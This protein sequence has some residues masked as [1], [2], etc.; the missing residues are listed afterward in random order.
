MKNMVR[1]EIIYSPQELG[2]KKEHS[3]EINSQPFT[4]DDLTKVVFVK[5]V[6]KDQSTDK[7]IQTIEKQYNFD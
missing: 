7:I 2:E 3:L 4:E 5:V 6:L 1:G